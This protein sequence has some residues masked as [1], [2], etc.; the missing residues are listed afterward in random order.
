MKGKEKRRSE[1]ILKNWR[2]WEKCYHISKT[3]LERKILSLLKKSE[4]NTVEALHLIPKEELKEN[5]SY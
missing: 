2:D 5:I 3:R 1:E 4:K